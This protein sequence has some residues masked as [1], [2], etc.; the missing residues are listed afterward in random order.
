[1]K[2]FDE[3][4]C[5]FEGCHNHLNKNEIACEAVSNKMALGPITNDLKDLR[6]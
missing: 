5:I 3:K 1:M 4:V 2:S 6:N